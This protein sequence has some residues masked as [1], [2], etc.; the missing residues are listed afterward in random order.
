MKKYLKYSLVGLM[1]LN[2]TGC[3]LKGNLFNNIND[4]KTFYSLN[5]DNNND[6]K[7]SSQI[8]VKDNNQIERNNKKKTI[9]SNGKDVGL[10]GKL[11]K[12]EKETKVENVNYK[13]NDNL[14][15]DYCHSDKHMLFNVKINDES[16][17][18]KQDGKEEII[19]SNIY[20]TS[21]VLDST[22]IKKC[23]LNEKNKNVEKTIYFAKSKTPERF[24]IESFSVKDVYVLSSYPLSE[25][26]FIKGEI[27][28]C[29]MNEN[30]F[31]FRIEET[32]IE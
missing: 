14:E 3:S 1:L 4:E 13:Y 12:D 8:E 27:S 19:S 17:S 24:L 31:N 18:K 25:V 2:L 15:I 21:F 20:T 32:I 29:F 6:N 9:V 7:C 11:I 28:I 22:D 23:N 10:I 26:N 30:N 5:M 16:K